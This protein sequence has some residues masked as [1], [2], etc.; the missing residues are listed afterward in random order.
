MIALAGLVSRSWKLA[1]AN[2]G[3]KNLIKRFPIRPL[4]ALGEILAR[5]DD[6]AKFFRGR[7]GHELFGRNAAFARKPLNLA[8]HTFWKF[9]RHFVHFVILLHASAGVITSIPKVLAAAVNVAASK[10]ISALA[11]P[12]TT[13]SRTISSS[14]SGTWG[15]QRNRI[16][17]GSMTL[18]SAFRAETTISLDTRA[19]LSKRADAHAPL[20]WA[21][22]RI[23]VSSTR[24]T[25]SVVTM[26]VRLGK[27]DLARA[28]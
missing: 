16:S 28:A 23:L 10:V 19:A 3:A 11:R 6:S 5:G 20:R 9:D 17:T 1:T 18:A 8:R 2:V 7:G 14:G 4:A 26:G 15:R 13:A 12:L 21:A 22:I 24:R 25:H 27:R